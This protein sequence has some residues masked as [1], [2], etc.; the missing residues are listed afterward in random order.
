M[1]NY[2][3]AKKRADETDEKIIEILKSG[4]S[5]RVEAGAGSGKTY[6]LHKVVEWIDK[7]KARDF[8]R[9]N[10]K[11][12]CIT[13]TNAAVDV[14]KNRIS[15]NSFIVPSTIHTFAWDTIKRFK[16]ALLVGVKQLNLLP[17]NVDGAEI[18]GVTYDLG[19]RYLED[20]NLHLFHDDVIKLFVWFL[21]KPKFCRLLRDQYP[22]IL[23]D[24]YQDSF[25]C[26][27][28]KLIEH[29][30]EKGTGPQLGLFGDAW[31][32]I[33]AN[34]GACGLIDNDKIVEIK[35]ESNFRSQQIIVDAL[36]KIRPK[37]PQISALNE[38][39]GSIV[40]ITTDSYHGS[41]IEKGYYKGE[42]PDNVLNEYITTVEEKLKAIGWNG[43]SKVLMIS[44]K[45]LAKQ[46]KYQL[47]LDALGNHFKDQD[48]KYFLF[49]RDI[50]EPLYYALEKQDVKA[51]YEVLGI[52]RQPIETKRQK[53]QWKDFTSKLCT[54]RKSTIADVV[55]AAIESKLIPIPPDIE[56]DANRYKIG[57]DYE[58][59]HTSLRK[60][61]EIQYDEMI[62]AINFFKPDALYSTEHGVKGEEYD[63]ILLVMGRGW[64]IY[65]FEDTLYKKE[66][67]LKGNELEGYIRNRNLFYVCCSR[68]KKRLAILITVEINKQFRTYLQHIFGAANVIDY[69][70]FIQAD[71]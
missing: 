49:F 41:R 60:F 70:S 59:A 40:V 38:N 19:I 55:N 43:N 13:Y 52:M 8:K 4:K 66:N 34:N 32:T 3:L 2:E 30:V 23:I 53:K 46:Q 28:D 57:E 26:I 33:Y 58:Y 6:S 20:G 24:E 45:L 14:I 9:T 54:A 5:F 50:L 36:N 18:K 47:L 35:K 15:S 12:A 31:Q 48:D 27:T 29:F 67:E 25:K 10:R 61:Y 37:L 16:S 65:K 69:N 68:P 56:N 39:D 11:V 44:H 63:N 17:P 62:N 1:T 42:L 21:D 7:N 71:N 64:N 51:M 22:I